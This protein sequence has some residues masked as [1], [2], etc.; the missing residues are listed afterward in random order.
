MAEPPSRNARD[1]CWTARDAYFGCLDAKGVLAPGE[2][3]RA[4]LSDRKRF[5]KDCAKSWVRWLTD[6]LVK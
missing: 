3:G 6:E 1:L 5:E 4:C 2:E